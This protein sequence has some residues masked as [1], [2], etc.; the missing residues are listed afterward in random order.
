VAVRGQSH[1]VGVALMLGLTVAALGTLTAGVG[2]V[3]QSQAAAADA[4]QVAGD[5]DT[6]LDETAHG[7]HSGRVHFSEGSLSTADRSVRVLRNGSVASEVDAGGLVFESGDRRTAYL[8]G[9]VVRGQGGAAWLT[10]APSVTSS[11]RNDVVV[12][13]VPRLGAD[14]VGV[15][16]TAGTAVTLETNV[17]HSRVDLGRGQFAV[18]VETATP[19]PLARHFREANATVSRQDFDDDGTPSVVAR[20]PGRRQGYLVVHDLALE[21]GNG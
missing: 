7:Y 2:T 19:D 16:G 8:A 3:L 4:S 6:A 11:E 5:L 14:G 18:A 15:G 12:V 21:V 13:G 1:V 10:E 17:S 9:A 20:Y